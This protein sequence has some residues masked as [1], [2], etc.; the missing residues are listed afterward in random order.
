MTVL[1]PVVGE[2]M[3]VYVKAPGR[4]ACGG[5][6][7]VVSGARSEIPGLFVFP[8]TRT[9]VTMIRAVPRSVVWRV[10]MRLGASASYRVCVCVYICRCSCFLCIMTRV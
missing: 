10:C 9:L 7:L 3:V 5:G 1:A 4:G 8:E 2:E 6:C